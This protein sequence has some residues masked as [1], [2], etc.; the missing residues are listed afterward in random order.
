MTSETT[1]LDSGPAGE[2][3]LCSTCKNPLLDVFTFPLVITNELEH[4]IQALDVID[5]SNAKARKVV[6]SYKALQLGKSQGCSF[7]AEVWASEQEFEAAWFSRKTERV[8][9]G[10]PGPEDAH[11]TYGTLKL[12]EGEALYG[13]EE[14]LVFQLS[15]RQDRS[16]VPR[17]KL[18]LGISLYHDGEWRGITTLNVLAERGTLCLVVSESLTKVSHR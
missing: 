16:G 18:V 1:M 4:E 6:T 13:D 11:V 15:L 3:L 17:K 9:Y 14:P 12:L 5:L 10:P 7:C 8:V 2:G